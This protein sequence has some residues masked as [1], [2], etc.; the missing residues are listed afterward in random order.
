MPWHEVVIPAKAGIHTS[1][2]LDSR[3][4]GN[5]RMIAETNERVPFETPTVSNSAADRSQY[6]GSA[7]TTR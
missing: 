2:R 7:D 5:D 6:A 3:L 1:R 4:R